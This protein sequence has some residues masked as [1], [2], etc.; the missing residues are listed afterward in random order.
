[1]DLFDTVGRRLYLTSEERRTF[2]E[3]A[4]AAPREVRT[5]CLVLHYTGCRISE[6][7]ALTPESFDF[8]GKAVIFETLKKRRR[9]IY[10]AVPVPGDMLDTLNMVHGL[11]E[12]LRRRRGTER[13]SPLWDWSRST[14]FRRVK[15]VMTAAGIAEA[16]ATLA[17]ATLVPV[18]TVVL[19]AMLGGMSLR[20]RPHLWDAARAMTVKY[21]LLPAL[22]VAVLSITEIGATN[23]L[24]ARFL[25]LRAASA[26]AVGLILQVRAYGGD[27][28]KVGTVML[29]SYILC[30]VSLPVWL[31]VWE[32]V[33]G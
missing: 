29:V 19:G 2:L 32:I 33:A 1:M 18:A 30:A 24:L 10:R 23:P 13:N 21:G 15:A 5:F 12:A 25:V 7:L 3:S 14:A 9:G 26:P 28:Q 16:A 6:S 20:L 22:T 27:E 31:A 11:T 17:A 4:E 8:S